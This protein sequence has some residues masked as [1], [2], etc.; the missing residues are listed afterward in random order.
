[1]KTKVYLAARFSRFPEMQG[2]KGELERA[3]FEVTSRWVSGEHQARDG[4]V[5]SQEDRK[6]FA[7]E[8]YGDLCKS[9]IIICFTEGPNPPGR[10][11]GG[12]HVEF[13]IALG[14][15]LEIHVVGHRENVF[16]CLP[17]VRF[18]EDWDHCFVELT[19]R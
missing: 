1:M 3:G 10:N 15:E 12:R 14:L 17:S 11:R 16:Y 2:Y 5:F 19:T 8:D 6:R 9:D 18:H 4:E 13:G 7:V